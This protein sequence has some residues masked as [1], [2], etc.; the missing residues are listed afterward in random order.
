MVAQDVGI[1]PGFPG[2]SR[3][4]QRFS[5]RHREYRSAPAGWVA[6]RAPTMRLA[7]R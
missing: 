4:N 2:D 7:I 6:M 1:A 3:V 5:Q